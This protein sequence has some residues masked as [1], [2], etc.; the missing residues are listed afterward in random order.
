[1]AYVTTR[2][3]L[4]LNRERHLGAGSTATTVS[5]TTSARSDDEHK[6]E[7][8]ER[9]ESVGNFRRIAT[10]PWN[11]PSTEVVITKWRSDVTGLRVVHVDYES[12]SLFLSSGLLFSWI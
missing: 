4:T 5:S 3:D 2:S 10:V 9:L 7:S 8:S 11:F 1:M 6:S 12:A